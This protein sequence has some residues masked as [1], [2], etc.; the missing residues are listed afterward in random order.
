MGSKHVPEGAAAV[1][2]VG[3]M[4]AALMPVVLALPTHSLVNGECDLAAA[5][6]LV[7]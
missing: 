1:A 6:L 4:S 2:A 3:G 5:I 7:A